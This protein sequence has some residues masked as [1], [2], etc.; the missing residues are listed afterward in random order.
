MS[1]L[2][3]TET[4]LNYRLKLAAYVRM[5]VRPTEIKALIPFHF[6]RTLR[7]SSDLQPVN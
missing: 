2:G 6:D 4:K 5:Y 7:T 1:F 3:S